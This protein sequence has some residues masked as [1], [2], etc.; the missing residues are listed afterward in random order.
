MRNMSQPRSSMKF[1]RNKVQPW[2]KHKDWELK[3]NFWIP[4][5]I[6]N[7][8][9]NWNNSRHNRNIKFY[10]CKELPL[11]RKSMLRANCWWKRKETCYPYMKERWNRSG[12]TKYPECCLRTKNDTVIL[13]PH[14]IIYTLIPISSH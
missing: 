2:R 3:N 13:F 10:R 6:G 7:N 12:K 9:K 14:N 4:W 8:E 5:L 11:R 1:S